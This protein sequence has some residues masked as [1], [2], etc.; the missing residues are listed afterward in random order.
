M[1]WLQVSTLV[2][3][4]EATN[5]ENWLVTAGATAIT[6]TDALDN[7]VYE[8]ERGTT[9]L[10]EAT[11]I[12]AL[13]DAKLDAQILL[14]QLNNLWK[15]QYP[16]LTPPEIKLEILEDKDWIR[17]WMDSFKPM[18]LGGSL[19]VVPSWLTPPDP[20]AVNLILDPGLAFG[21]GTHPTTR[22]CLQWLAQQDLT[23]KN[24]LDFGCG[25]GI[26]GIA[27]LLLGAKQAWGVD[28]DPQALQASQANAQRNNLPASSF[29]VY[30]PENCPSLS[31]E[32]VMANILAG[33]LI[34]LAEVIAA[35]VAPKGWLVLSGIL[36]QQAEEVMQAY[37]A[38]FDFSAPVQDEDWMLLSA[39]RR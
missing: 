1:S 30:Y 17:E 32:V 21:T 28:I 35:K 26:L 2:K 8:P 36:A 12:T 37:A 15:Q 39:Q 11:R 18:H 6:L 9:P 27:G 29:P 34:S 20:S 4:E 5:F 14:S 22:L 38:W 3:P 24:L 25:S 19:W 13:Y 33:P 7:P 16:Q 10:W 23:G 31:C